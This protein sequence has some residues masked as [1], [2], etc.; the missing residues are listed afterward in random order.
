MKSFKEHLTAIQESKDPVD[1]EIFRV[2]EKKKI[3]Y[4]PQNCSEQK[5]EMT[6]KKHPGF[7][8]KYQ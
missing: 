6:K 2:D 7:K 8:V 1:G 5:L 4:A 3:I